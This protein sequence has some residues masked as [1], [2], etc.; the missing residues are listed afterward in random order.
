MRPEIA[1]S[2]QS[3]QSKLGDNL[4]G[5]LEE[6]A[7]ATTPNFRQAL[8]LEHLSGLQSGGAMPLTIGSYRFGRS[9]SS[10]MFDQGKPHDPQFG[11]T[12]DPEG[13][14]VLYPPPVGVMLDGEKVMEP[15]P[16]TIGQ[17]ITIGHN[18]FGLR[19]QAR[20]AVSRTSAS[21]DAGTPMPTPAKG[22]GVDQTIL[23]WVGEHRD[24][25]LRLMWA[26]LV[27]PVE[28]HNRITEN[29]LFDITIHGDRFGHVLL[30]ATDMAY[31]LPL[32]LEN[33]NKA[34]K[35]AAEAAFDR[36]PGAPISVDLAHASVALVGPREQCRAVATWMAISLAAQS[37]PTCLS[38]NVE[39][40]ND[41]GS[42]S[43][44]ERLPHK[45]QLE[46]QRLAVNI[47]D[48]KRPNVPIT[49]GTVVMYEG[50]VAVP[51]QFDVVLELSAHAATFTDRTNGVENA[52]QHEI[53]AIGLANAVAV[54][55]S[56]IISQHLASAEEESWG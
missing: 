20:L 29:D 37:A 55:R 26:D 47:V 18:R 31:Q 30:G 34:T 15:R 4:G 17:T 39:N 46:T 32:E 41:S 5:V 22:R 21:G 54:E 2:L 24:R 16:M 6:E 19:P 28:I 36:L 45:E 43:W 23:D 14:V 33:A 56:L 52:V 42:W 40:S 35:E 1:A 51:D 25:T 53:A 10:I 12:V 49:N 44:L 27:G 11:L 3:I 48:E 38:I 13:V 50:A 7:S 9:S 8:V